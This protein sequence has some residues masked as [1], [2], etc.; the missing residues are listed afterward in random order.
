MRTPDEAKDLLC[1]LARTFAE[2]P[3]V[4]GCRGPLC[5]LWRWETIT[6]KHPLWLPAVQAKAKETGEKPPYAEASKWVAKNLADLGMTPKVGFC[7]AGGQ[8]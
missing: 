8:S 7:G 3:A 2:T 4:A 1:P 6:T 5:M